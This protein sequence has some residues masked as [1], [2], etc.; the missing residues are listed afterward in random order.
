MLSAIVNE[1]LVQWTIGIP[2]VYSLVNVFVRLGFRCPYTVRGTVGANMVAFVAVSCLCCMYVGVAGSLAWL[3]MCGNCDVVEIG[4]DRLYGRSEFFE[5]HLAVPLLTY[6]FWNFVICLVVA[7]L[8]EGVPLIHHLSSGLCALFT[9]RPYLQYYGLFFFGMPELS[10][11]PLAF[12]TLSKCF[13]VLKS[14]YPV[15]HAVSRWSFGVLFLIIRL[16]IWTYVSCHFWIDVCLLLSEGGGKFNFAMGY[17][18]FAHL[19]LT[20]MQYY[21]GHTIVTQMMR[22]GKEEKKP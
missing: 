3:N 1:R 21:W 10:S 11:V 2:C 22:G 9:M 6:Q 20:A 17:F 12:V 7:E 13:P 4:K 15:V 16:I 5:L 14:N 18:C 19:L 8:R